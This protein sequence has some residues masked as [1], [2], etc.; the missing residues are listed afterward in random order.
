MGVAE[1]NMSLPVAFLRGCNHNSAPL[2]FLLHFGRCIFLLVSL[3]V[4]PQVQ[5]ILGSTA[6]HG[7]TILQFAAG[8]G[9][10]ESFEA[11]LAA[12]KKA[13]N[14]EKVRQVSAPEIIL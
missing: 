5:T 4:M 7:K 14:V 9:N 8:S 13:F 12:V 11:V 6:K 3:A 10:K 1:K 2:P